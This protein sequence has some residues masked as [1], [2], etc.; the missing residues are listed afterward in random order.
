MSGIL[1]IIQKVNWSFSEMRQ[2]KLI[3]III[4]SLLSISY[5]SASLA[6][7]TA[8]APARA[9]GSG[10]G[11]NGSSQDRIAMS[12]RSAG[13]QPWPRR[14]APPI[15][16]VED[17]PEACLPLVATFRRSRH[18]QKLAERDEGQPRRAKRGLRLV[19]LRETIPHRGRGHARRPCGPAAPTEGARSRGAAH[20]RQSSTVVLCR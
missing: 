16:P 9:A 7:S 11:G 5:I 6:A 18:L 15:V 4:L 13:R 2:I 12:P 8:A 3:L 19:P 10:G 17:P 14:V 20:A 1:R